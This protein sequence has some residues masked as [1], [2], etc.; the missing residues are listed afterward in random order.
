MILFCWPFAIK[1]WCEL[2]SHPSIRSL[3][4]KEYFIIKLPVYCGERTDGF[5]RARFY[6][7]RQDFIELRSDIQTEIDGLM[8]LVLKR[9]GISRCWGDADERRSANISCLSASNFVDR[10]DFKVLVHQNFLNTF[11]IP[12]ALRSGICEGTRNSFSFI[13]PYRLILRHTTSERRFKKKSNVLCVK[14]FKN[15]IIF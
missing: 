9:R 3:M 13:Y 6:T 11:N 14:I 2:R 8:W 15:S 5:V 12:Y 7:V 4:K 10:V 1:M